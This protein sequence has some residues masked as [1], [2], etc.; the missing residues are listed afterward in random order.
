MILR[1]AKKLPTNDRPK[2]VEAVHL[3]YQRYEDGENYTSI[4]MPPRFGKS[5]IIRLLA[6]ELHRGFPALMT[7]PWGDNVDQIKERDKI[8]A[9]FDRYEIKREEV[10]TA[11]RRSA[12]MKT[13][14]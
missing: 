11:K 4:D 2:I 5:D 8:E 10:F 3:S 1:Y 6:M 12:T 14:A 7:A 9:M 13:H